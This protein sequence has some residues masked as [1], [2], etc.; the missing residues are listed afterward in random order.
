MNRIWI[1]VLALVIGIVAWPTAWSEEDRA[2]Q[3][4]ARIAET[5]ERLKLSDEQVEQLTPILKSSIEAQMG[6]L[7][8][9]GIDLENRDSENQK[10]LSFREARKLRK[11]LDVV[12]KSSLEQVEGILSEKQFA[13]YKEIQEERRKKMREMIKDRR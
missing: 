4:E 5:R 3:I 9:H 1:F 8:K 13:E 12:R 2:A 7:E 11:D 10:R 6:V